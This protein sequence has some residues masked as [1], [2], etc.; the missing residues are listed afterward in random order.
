MALQTYLLV[1]LILLGAVVGSF[2]NVCIYRLP[3]GKSILWPASHCPKCLRPVRA[4]DNIPILSYFVLR[5]RCRD[6][7]EHFS[8]RYMLIEALT[9]WLFGVVFWLHV[10]QA[11]AGQ[12]NPLAYACHMAL[13]AALIVATFID[14]DL[15]IIPDSVTVPGMLLG[16]AMGWLVPGAVLHPI[17]DPAPAPVGLGQWEKLIFGLMVLLGWTLWAGSIVWQVR[18]AHVPMASAEVVLL[19]ASFLYLGGRTAVLAGFPS[20][21]PVLGWP[22]WFAAHPHWQGLATSTVGLL[23]GAGLVWIVRVIG[24]AALRKEAMGFGDV[25]LMG[26]VGAFLGWQPAVIVFFLA[27]FFGLVVGLAQW[28]TRGNKVIP[29]GPFLSLATLVVLLLWDPIWRIVQGHFQFLA[30]IP[31]CPVILILLPVLAVCVVVNHRRD[32]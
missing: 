30:M 27:P 9:A 18:I 12:A 3:W 8:P 28:I 4:Y 22:A 5:G 7:G 15:Q 19:G 26:M 16:L 25:T 29:Y 6:C 32:Q 1:C 13:V 10:A 2:L 14:L 11:P 23:V 21:W 17:L 31:A 24:S 20:N